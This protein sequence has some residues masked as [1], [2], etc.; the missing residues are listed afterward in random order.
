VIEVPVAC[1][2]A[3]LTE[4]ENFRMGCGILIPFTAVFPDSNEGLAGFCH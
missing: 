3:A 4:G 1:P 2:Q